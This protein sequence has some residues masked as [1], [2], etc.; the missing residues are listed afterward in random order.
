MPMNR[1]AAPLAVAL[2][3]A[4]LTWAPTQATAEAAPRSCVDERTEGDCLAL[5]SCRWREDSCERDDCA[6]RHAE[7]C[8]APICGWD[9]ERC[10]AASEGGD[11]EDSDGCASVPGPGGRAGGAVVMLFALGLFACRWGAAASARGR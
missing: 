1:P 3:G 9:G 11:A 5:A 8:V 4:L 10:R 7:L 2:F 6:G